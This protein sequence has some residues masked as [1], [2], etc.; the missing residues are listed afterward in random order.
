MIQ[1]RVDK[2]AVDLKLEA[3]KT[4]MSGQF[5]FNFIYISKTLINRN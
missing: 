5:A 4:F 2:L 1:M 3:I